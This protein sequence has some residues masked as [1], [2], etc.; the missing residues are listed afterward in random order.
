MNRAFVLLLLFVFSNPVSSIAVE[1]VGREAAAKYF[2]PSS[3]KTNLILPRLLALHLGGYTESEAFVWGKRGRNDDIGKYTVGVTYR[4]GE[5]TNSMD[6]HIRV[7]FN[8]YELEN[9]R[10]LKMSFL[11][12]ITFPDAASGFPLY[13]GAGAGVGVFF[14]QLDG[15]SNLSLD[16]QILAGVR[17]LD[18]FGST[19]VFFESGMKNHLHLLSDGQVNAVFVATGAVFRF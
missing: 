19:G 4:V 17:M 16:Y 7:D 10:P 11:P 14:K 1:E 8:R 13:F 3:P 15:E 5:W 18:V 9:E 12:L 6:L 2:T